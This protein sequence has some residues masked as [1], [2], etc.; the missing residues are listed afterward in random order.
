MAKK[1]ARCG[2][3]GAAAPGKDGLCRACRAVEEGEFES[4]SAY[5]EDLGRRGGRASARA[6]QPEGLNLE[7]LPRLEGHGEVKIWLEH[8]GRELAAGRASKDLV[9]ELRKILKE[10]LSAHRKEVEDE[11]LADLRERLDRIEEEQR[12]RVREEPWRE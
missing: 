6:R 3:C 7:G 2:E 12:K 10:W 1:Q 9:S 4:R 5:Y 8:L 11:V